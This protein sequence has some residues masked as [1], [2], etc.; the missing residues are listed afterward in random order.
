MSNKILS[1]LYYRPILQ[2][3]NQVMASSNFVTHGINTLKLVHFLVNV[4]I[5]W[6]L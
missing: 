5:E 2:D 1:L 6:K 3:G 4:H